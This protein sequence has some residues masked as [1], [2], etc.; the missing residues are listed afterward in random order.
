MK[1][2]QKRIF[3]NNQEDKDFEVYTL[4]PENAIADTRHKKRQQIQNA[5]F[6]TALKAKEPGSIISINNP[7]SNS[8]KS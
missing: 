8:N 3:V 7:Y 6:E 1:K 4:Y 2:N 5:G